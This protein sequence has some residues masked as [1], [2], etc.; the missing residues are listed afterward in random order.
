MFISDQ[1]KNGKENR[2]NIFGVANQFDNDI[3]NIGKIKGGK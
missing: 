1:Q 3:L 2:F